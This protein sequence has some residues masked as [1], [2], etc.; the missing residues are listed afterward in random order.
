MRRISK[1]I[2]LCLLLSIVVSAFAVF[3]FGADATMS[4]TVVYDMEA[5]L[6]QAN[7]IINGDPA[8][9]NGANSVQFV[10]KEDVNKK[11]YYQH[12]LIGEL[13]DNGT[14]KNPNNPDSVYFGHFASS[15]AV[16]VNSNMYGD[17][18]TDF[19]VIDFDF[20]TDGT[21]GDFCFKNRWKTEIAKNAQSNLPMITGS[22]IDEGLGLY[23]CN[24]KSGVFTATSDTYY[25]LGIDDTGWVDITLIYDFRGEEYTKWK[26]YL[27]LNGVYAGEIPTVK[28]DAVL[29]EQ[30]RFVYDTTFS[31]PEATVNLANYTIKS[32][33]VDYN[34]EIAT[35]IDNL[36][37]TG[38]RI[39]DFADLGYCLED[40]PEMLF[41]TVE[42][43]GEVKNIS[44]PMALDASL[45]DG[46]KVTLYGDLV[47]TIIVPH[48]ADIEWVT[49]GRYMVEPKKVNYSEVN[50]VIRDLDTGEVLSY[51]NDTIT[52]DE[53][54]TPTVGIETI[55]NQNGY[56]DP[57]EWNDKSIKGFTTNKD[58]YGRT[59]WTLIAANAPGS[60]NFSIP[61]LAGLTITDTNYLVFDADLKADSNSYEYIEHSFRFKTSDGTVN[62]NAANFRYIF[63]DGKVGVSNAKGDTKYCSSV[64]N[65]WTH[66]TVVYDFTGTSYNDWKAYAYIDGKFA[67][68]L[69]L[70]FMDGAKITMAQIE[71]R[72][73]KDSDSSFDIANWS[74]NAFGSDYNGELGQTLGND[75]SKIKDLGYTLDNVIGTEV[76]IDTTNLHSGIAEFSK[77]HNIRAT[78]L[79]NA[80]YKNTVPVNIAK[81]LI[82]DLGEHTL[83]TMSNKGDGTTPPHSFTISNTI[84]FNGGKG[85]KI[86]VKNEGNANLVYIGED[87][88]SNNARVIFNGTDIQNDADHPLIEQKNGNVSFVR[89]KIDVKDASLITTGGGKVKT[90]LLIDGCTVT[91]ARSAIEITNNSV[92]DKITGSLD[93]SVEIVNSTVTAGGHLVDIRS[94][95]NETGEVSGGAFVPGAGYGDNNNVVN[96][97]VVGSTVDVSGSVVYSEIA[98]IR[99]DCYDVDGD[100]ANDV[101]YADNFKLV[102]NT[103]IVG[104]IIKAV[105]IAQQ[106]VTENGLIPSTYSLRSAPSVLHDTNVDIDTA[107]ITLD[108]AHATKNIPA[109][110]DTIDITYSGECAISTN[111]A[112]DDGIEGVSLNIQSG[113]YL[114]PR[115]AAG[116]APYAVTTNIAPYP[117][118]IGG[119]E[120][121][122]L[123]YAGDPIDNDIIPV[124]V[125]TN[126][127]YVDFKW[128]DELDENGAFFLE[129]V[130]TVP[131]KANMTLSNN[132]A[133]N[134]YLPAD[135]GDNTY[136]TLRV[137]GE[138]V[139]ITSVNIDGTDYKAI[140][141][142]DI[143]PVNAA[144]E[145]V[146]SYTVYTE[147]GLSASTSKTVSI[148]DYARSVLKNENETEKS[149]E[150]IAALVNY[151]AKMYAAAGRE[152]SAL[153]ALLN[154]DEYKAITLTKQLPTAKSTIGE[155]KDGDGRQVFE[156]VGLTA[157]DNFQLAF[158]TYEGFSGNLVFTY[159][160]GGSSF[161][162]TIMVRGGEVITLDIKAY[163]LLSDITI[164]YNGVSGEYNLSAYIDALVK[165]QAEPDIIALAEALAIY[166][167]YANA[168]Y[169]G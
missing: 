29:F 119:E 114:V 169:Y 55:F 100:G 7:G 88:A 159:C 95:A 76:L 44:N 104:C 26:A 59:Y 70:S 116:V 85:S 56:T 163:D 113:Y 4:P 166:S 28:N 63:E 92:S 41:A 89:C 153:T 106:H 140:S 152:D 2:A 61:N 102:T 155:I 68:D 147:D 48:D 50:V 154:L 35:K 128:A 16:I 167:S 36:G 27:Y 18:N 151:I 93:A 79:G 12:L 64:A 60:H 125:T 86:V 34:G 54:E 10:Y 101:L 145:F 37:A 40:K 112:T 31:A 32:F 42:R 77:L 67:G 75:I 131:M 84:V 144:E 15:N 73:A 127:P 9:I 39:S 157:G 65:A 87:E 38:S 94:Y 118:I 139:A 8:V 69:K 49:N 121:E 46:D 158:R 115:S 123:W 30:S 111:V 161:M 14:Y 136:N 20:S 78:F 90:S 96:V 160:K 133:F 5:S 129:T 120:Y 134:L 62:K 1:V 24:E 57:P 45:E 108:N 164:R 74:I 137:N 97:S 58:N 52:D 17:K 150:L 138:K 19:F 141:I 91:S 148:I 146:L 165:E 3:S 149:R 25:P 142:K 53:V 71:P 22:T 109:S 51:A 122:F 132:F 80:T 23:T 162:E 143:S 21:F 130:V 47:N 168:Y 156:K 99:N 72:K 98:D 83:T 117:Y 81:R 66:V 126:S 124:D 33:P 11:P 135:L 82:L 107:E 43:D 110:S 103:G 105:Y 6:G 13:Q